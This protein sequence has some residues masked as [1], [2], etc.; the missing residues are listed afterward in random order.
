MQDPIPP[1]GRGKKP[2]LDLRKQRHL[3]VGGVWCQGNM[4]S[5]IVQ[6]L[7]MTALTNSG[8]GRDC[9]GLVLDSVPGQAL[10]LEKEQVNGLAS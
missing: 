1:T 4:D 7:S 8:Q 9:N 6:P 3:H 2:E 5:T 10:S